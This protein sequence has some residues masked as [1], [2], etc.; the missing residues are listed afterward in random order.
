MHKKTIDCEWKP[1]FHNHKRQKSQSNLPKPEMSRTLGG[2]IKEKGARANN[3]NFIRLIAAILVVLSHAFN[4]S[5]G[6]ADWK[7]HEF[8]ARISDGELSLGKIAV[9]CFF[10]LS[11]Y[12]I[13][14]SYVKSKNN[15]EFFLKRFIRIYPGLLFV[16]VVT[17]FLIT[18]I[19]SDKGVI[20]N[21]L[22]KENYLYIIHN[23]SFLVNN[24]KIPGLFT[25]HPLPGLVNGSLW[26]LKHEMYCYFTV[27]LCVFLTK[28]K[29]KRIMAVFG[30]LTLINIL[31][32]F[33]LIGGLN[34]DGGFAFRIK[35]FLGL[36]EYF[37]AGVFV[38]SIRDSII[39]S[40]KY[41]LALFPVLC[42]SIFIPSVTSIAFATI[43]T[44]ILFVIGYSPKISMPS[45]H[46][47]GDLSYGIYIF[48]WPIQQIIMQQAG[49]S[50]SWY[51]NFLLSMPFILVLACISWNC[52]E[53]PSL[54]FKSLEQIPYLGRHLA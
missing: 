18:P 3:L 36:Y 28:N 48:G 42:A 16:L 14:A 34:W 23:L 20:Q 25:N 37:L 52:I 11:G 32:Y 51:A 5:Y 29:P 22:S 44:Y 24:D 15:A 33:N 1:S 21:Y 53:K 54:K 2:I 35:R 41:A 27:P 49:Y 31:F 6:K 40:R 50:M 26:S 38:Y 30:L 9:F 46:K 45:V 17:V 8:L 39:I 4:I 43:G 12:L 7:S 47:I 19:Y 10:I 13:T